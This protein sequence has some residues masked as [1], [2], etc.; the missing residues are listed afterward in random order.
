MEKE[1]IFCCASVSAHQLLPL[2]SMQ[3]IDI[4][5]CKIM[6]WSIYYKVDEKKFQFNFIKSHI[7]SE[8]SPVVL[9]MCLRL[10]WSKLTT[11]MEPL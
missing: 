6:Q 9:F 8:M 2:Y 3:Y 7:I 5:M 1:Q 10:W 4:V 11:I